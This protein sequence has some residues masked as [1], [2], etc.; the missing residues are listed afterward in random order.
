MMILEQRALAEKG[1][2]LVEL[3]IDWLS[4]KPDI[5]RLLAE[6][7]TETLIACRRLNDRGRWRGSEDQRLQ[8][9]RE[10]IAAEVDYIDLEDDIAGSIPR[11]KN[12]KRVISHHN[13]D[14]TPEDLQSIHDRMAK[15]DPDIIKLVTMANSPSDAVRMLKLVESSKIPTIGFCMGELGIVSRILCGKYGAPYTYSTFSDERTMAPGQLSFSDMKNIYRFDQINKETKVYGVLGDPIGH[16]LSPLIH[17]AAFQ[18]LGMDAVYVPIRVQ[19]DRLT[20]TLK[21]FEWLDF[22]GYSVTIP[23]KES[24]LKLYD[25]HD[26]SVRAIGA[27]NTIYRDS[28]GFWKIT[29]TDY[30]A[31]LE[32][33][34]QG[35][36]ESDIKPARISGKQVLLLGAGGVARAIG[37]GLVKENAK[38]VIAN[39]TAEKAE[40]LAKELGCQHQKWENRG[41]TFYD[42]IVNCTRVGMHPDVDE[43]P[44]APN[45]LSEKQL[46]FDTVYNPENTLLL[47]EAR[48]RFSHTVSGIEMFVRQAAAQFQLFTQEPAPIDVMREALRSGISAISR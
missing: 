8:L 22:Q 17:N 11:Y 36:L 5:S 7:P 13:F 24:I 14:E 30:E 25:Q 28:N 47:K 31:A 23:H 46:V 44:Y 20:K 16:S 34:R 15:L 19:A 29:N 6:R 26:A 45:L 10:A 40:K 37:L 4:R 42:I 2:E 27:A 12:E 21:D 38:V 3:R 35:L 33:I 43:S 39:R 1:A 48:E 41:T 18:H 9:L 32:S